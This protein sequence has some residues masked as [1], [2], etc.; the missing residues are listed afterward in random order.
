MI[1][2]YALYGSEAVSL[3]DTPYE[4]IDRERLTGFRIVRVIDTE[5]QVTEKINAIKAEIQKIES[6]RYELLRQVTE[7][8]NTLK[9][10][11]GEEKEVAKKI[12]NEE[13]VQNK[14]RTDAD[15][16]IKPLQKG[17]AYHEKKIVE[18]AIEQALWKSQKISEKVIFE[19][20]IEQGQRLI[21][22]KRQFLKPYGVTIDVQVI[23]W[24]RTVNGTNVQSIT[25][26]REDGTVVLTGKWVENSAL[27]EEPVLLDFE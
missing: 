27:L 8:I 20:T 3:K 2:P 9:K 16:V 23:G 6:Q 1:T 18:N 10:E 19:M 25:L 26:I 15:N 11:G 21:W 4:R 5:A 24:Q 13:R 7:T 14:I 12:R 17:I 22:R